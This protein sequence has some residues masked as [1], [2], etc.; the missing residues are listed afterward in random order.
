MSRF[1]SLNW[2][3]NKPLEKEYSV[4]IMKSTIS[5][6]EWVFRPPELKS[7]LEKREK[8]KGKNEKKSESEV[9]S[10]KKHAVCRIATR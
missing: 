8:G 3:K 5:S 4:L 7:K 1:I 10:Q 2:Q 6:H 9:M